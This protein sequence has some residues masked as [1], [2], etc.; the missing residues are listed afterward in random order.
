MSRKKQAFESE[1]P[2]G[3]KYTHSPSPASLDNCS[4]CFR[5]EEYSTRNN[6][7]HNVSTFGLDAR[8]RKCAMVLQ[9]EKLL[10]KL[11]AG[12]LAALEAKYHDPWVA[13]LYRKT[14][15]V[16]EEGEEDE[17]IP[18][19]PKGIEL[20]ELQ[21]A[22]KLLRHSY[23]LE[24]ISSSAARMAPSPAPPGQ[25]CVFLFSTSLVD[26]GTTLIRVGEGRV[27]RKC[28]FWTSFLCKQ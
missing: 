13:S 22:S 5:C 17:T 25:C 6:P 8:V 24:S 26:S 18:R 16:K 9:D 10:A 23:A 14:E 2:V 15:R 27:A 7:L 12:D 3:R 11:S 19:L 20:A 28:T 1:Q 21:S 4:T